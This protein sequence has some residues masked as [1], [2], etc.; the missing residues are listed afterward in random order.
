MMTVIAIV[1]HPKPLLGTL[2]HE[3][4]TMEQQEVAAINRISG[5][6]IEEAFMIPN[7]TVPLL[8]VVALCVD[9]QGAHAWVAST[10]TDWPHADPAE[11]GMDAARLGEARDYA[12]TGEG[13]G[14]VVRGGTVVMTWGNIDRL[15]DLNSTTKSFGATALGLAVA[16]GKLSLDD[17]VVDRHPS[18]GVPPDSNREMGWLDEVTLRHLTTHTAG[19]AKRGGYEPLLFRPGTAWHDSDGGPNWLA[20][21]V[22]LAYGRDLEDLMFERVFEPIGISRDDLRWRAHAYRPHKIDGILSR[23]F[24]SGI[25]A[26]VDAMA[27]LGSLYLRGGQ[28]QDQQTLSRDFIDAARTPV[29]DV[30]GLP[31]YGSEHHGNASD[32][33]GLLWWIN[34]DGTL[35]GVPRDAYWSWGLYDSLIVVIPSLDLVACRAGKSWDREDVWGHDKVLAPFLGPLVASV[36][37]VSP[38]ADAPYPPSSTFIGIDWAPARAI[39]RR[40]LGSDNWPMTWAD[41]DTQITAFGDGHGFRPFVPEKL[42]LG[43]SR[44]EGSPDD[45]KGQNLRSQS[46]ERIG[47]GASGLKASGI[48]SV[49]GTLY[50]L[51]RNADNAQLAWSEDRGATWTWADW[52]FS[53]SFNFGRD[54]D[55]AR[56]KYVYIDSPDSNSAYESCGRLV[57]AR[58]PIDQLTDRGAY[59][60]FAG[61]DDEGEPHWAR[62]IGAR[63][64]VFEN[65]GRVYRSS[66]TYNAPLGRDLL[67][68][69]LAEPGSSN[70]DTRFEGGFGIYEAPEPWGPWRTVFFTN[71]WDVSPG[72]TQSLPSKWMSDDGTTVHLVFSG[73]DTF[74]VR[75]A[76][77]ILPADPD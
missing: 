60:F 2:A 18:F 62:E 27:R 7:R 73:D 15:Y 26:N 63:A 74:A 65:P 10:D 24:G 59:R 25:H 43:L 33:Y 20:E 39:V 16:D 12:L 5:S 19:F 58:V 22:T 32:H 70:V 77:L 51:V 34:A 48:L 9:L 71:C 75:Q 53:E 72:E 6:P 8:L 23:E 49:G 67:C 11:V 42:S 38:S 47:D 54:Y 66:I 76:R 40:A 64:S 46:L 37:T 55:G 3:G 35:P 57:L 28:W 52:R 31:E 68:Q 14:M 69:T 56:D 1:I 61:L 21:C 29:E 30:V 44:V 17:R 45:P 4:D 41:D 13:S 50:L 36:Q